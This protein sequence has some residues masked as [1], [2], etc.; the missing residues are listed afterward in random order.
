MP[1]Y[2]QFGKVLVT[3]GVRHS[4]GWGRRVAKNPVKSAQDTRAT[5]KRDAHPV[6]L[7]DRT[8][9]A[10]LHEMVTEMLNLVHLSHSARLI[11]VQPLENGE[12]NVL[13]FPLVCRSR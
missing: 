9:C 3:Q 11:M 1:H 10:I 13:A 7:A 2:G 5:Q 8:L 6:F 12:G 4:F